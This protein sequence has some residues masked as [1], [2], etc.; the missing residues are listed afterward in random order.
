MKSKNHLIYIQFYTEYCYLSNEG[1]W[2][3]RIFRVNTHTVISSSIH[4]SDQLETSYTNCARNFTTIRSKSFHPHTLFS[5]KPAAYSLFRK[6]YRAASRHLAFD[7]GRWSTIHPQVI[8]RSSLSQGTHG[9]RH[10][11]RKVIAVQQQLLK[12]SQTASWHFWNRAGEI[13]IGKIH[14][15]QLGTVCK[16]R[17]Q[18]SLKVVALQIQDFE[19]LAGHKDGG[20]DLTCQCVHSCVEE[21]ERRSIDG[22]DG[23][24]QQV[25]AYQDVL[26]SS[27]RQGGSVRRRATTRQHQRNKQ[28]GV[29][30][31]RS[32]ASLIEAG[33]VPVKELF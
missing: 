31:P 20:R 28:H 32:V 21:F 12:G 15:N 4:A 11:A 1:S 14:V 6:A 13:V 19:V 5:R 17:W 8:Q 2:I 18:R 30:A 33:M 7:F 24:R 16:C 10:A 29:Y 27:N 22:W 23:S 26:C 9:C 25:P 3:R